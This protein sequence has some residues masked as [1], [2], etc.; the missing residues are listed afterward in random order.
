MT[1]S[2]AVCK[3]AMPMLIADCC[4][5]IADCRL[6]MAGNDMLALPSSSPAQAGVSFSAKLALWHAIDR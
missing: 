5:L 2:S 6:L 4:L 3:K 1:D